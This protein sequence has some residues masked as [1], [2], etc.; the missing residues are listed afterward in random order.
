MHGWHLGGFIALLVVIAISLL[1][2]YQSVGFLVGAFILGILTGDDFGYIARGKE[3][4]HD[5]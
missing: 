4:A 5:Q 1:L 3:G 2:G